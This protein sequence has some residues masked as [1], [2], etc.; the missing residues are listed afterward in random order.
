MAT[1]VSVGAPLLHTHSLSVLTR[2]RKLFLLRSADALGW[3]GCLRAVAMAAPLEGVGGSSILKEQLGR[4]G[5]EEEKASPHLQSRDP[6]G[7]TGSQPPVCFPI[8]R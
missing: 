1:S 7:F 6:V 2:A 3:L 4:G 5:E 8:E